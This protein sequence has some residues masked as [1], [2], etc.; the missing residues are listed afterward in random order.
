VL[1]KKWGRPLF[2]L[3]AF[4]LFLPVARGEAKDWKE[5][6]HQHFI[7]FYEEAPIDFVE[8]IG[9]MAEDY[10]QEITENLGFIRY[11]GWTWDDRAKIYI[12]NDSEDYV[13]TAKAAQWSHGVAS[14]ADKVI[15]T[16]PA[17][18]GFFDST[19]PHELGH[20]IFREFVGFKARVPHWFEEGVAMYQE[21][22][23]RWGSHK[24]VRKAIEEG[25]FIPLSDLTLTRLTHRTKKEKVNLFYAESA[26]IIQYLIGEWGQQRFVRLCRKLQKGDPF[27][28]TIDEV[29]VQFKNIEDLNDAWVKFLKSK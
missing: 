20:I 24:I 25:V 8:S 19:L 12:Y 4:F 9:E 22:G 14:P 6:K 23:R 28:W 17:A 13:M 26:S 27:E 2:L 7:V 5:Y 18:H 21:K 3:F 15:R 1:N 29:Y 16:F 11:K 10:Y